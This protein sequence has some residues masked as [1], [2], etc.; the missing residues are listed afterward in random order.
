[1]YP[2]LCEA[3]ISATRVNS[4]C[5]FSMHATTFAAAVFRGSLS[6]LSAKQVASIVCNVQVISFFTRQSW[7]VVPVP[8]VCSD[9]TNETVD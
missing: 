7:I 2:A 3:V 1:M 6:H 4:W 8:V 9:D 5:I